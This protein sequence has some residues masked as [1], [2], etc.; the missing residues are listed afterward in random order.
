LFIARFAGDRGGA[1]F[2]VFVTFPGSAPASPGEITDVGLELLA[3]DLL[4]EVV[5]ALTPGRLVSVMSGPREVAELEVL[6][7]A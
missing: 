7:P 4:P 6:P 2:S 5:D 1:T 3:P